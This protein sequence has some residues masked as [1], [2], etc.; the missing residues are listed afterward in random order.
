MLHARSLVSL[1]HKCSMALCDWQQAT[2]RDII[3]HLM[4]MPKSSY[5]CLI[6]TDKSID[7]QVDSF[8]DQLIDHSHG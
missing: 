7:E 4:R 5:A 3:S 6:T 2:T 8:L 1:I